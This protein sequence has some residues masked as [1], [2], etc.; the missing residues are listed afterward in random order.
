[1]TMLI[2]N[3]KVASHFDFLSSEYDNYK[4]KAQY[5]YQ[6]VI[7]GL[8]RFI[9]P[10]K[11]V[12]ELGCGTGTILNKL[13]PRF[14]LGIDI[15]PKMIETA[16]RNYPHLQFRVGDIDNLILK[17][18]FDFVVMVDLVEHLSNLE[19]S[20]NKLAETIPPHTT[21]ISSSANPLWAPVLHA[22]EKLKM[23]M[24]EGDHRWP[25]VNE[26]KKVM[27]K[28]GF[29]VLDVYRHMVIPKHI[30]FVS[31]KINRLFPNRGFLASLSLIQL[32]V[33]KKNEKLAF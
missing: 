23:K 29:R 30:P 28:A 20:F 19:T 22:A 32:V 17:E 7:E 14:G 33:F 10:N 25:S 5:Y 9:P 11:R 31:D 4:I 3:K 2:D 27:E 13:Q 1:M 6:T 8:H 26:L 24:P 12:L 21:L 16:R 15:S 18:T